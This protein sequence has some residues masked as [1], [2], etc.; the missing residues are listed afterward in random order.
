MTR[1]GAYEIPSWAI[2]ILFWRKVHQVESR[3]IPG[4]R[5]SQRF[6]SK[7]ADSCAIH[8]RRDIRQLDG[9]LNV[10]MLETLA[11]RYRQSAEQCHRSWHRTPF[12]KWA[13]K[14]SVA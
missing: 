6:C 8:H 9:R 10:E 4:I 1:L 2:A 13:L 11:T 7:P 3:G 5:A 12:F 14:R